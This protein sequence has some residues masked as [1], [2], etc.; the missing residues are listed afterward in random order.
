MTGVE[1]IDAIRLISAKAED[2]N[3]ILVV[4]GFDDDSLQQ[5][6]VVRGDESKIREQMADGEVVIGSV[7]SQRTKLNVGN[8]LPLETD[9]GIKPFRIA[10]IVTDYQAGGLTVYMDRGTAEKQLDIGGVDVYVVKAARKK[11]TRCGEIFWIS[12]KTRA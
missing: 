9:E 12:C 4:R 10:A 8:T 7:L 1:G 11:L 5:F 2:Q 6:D 3:V